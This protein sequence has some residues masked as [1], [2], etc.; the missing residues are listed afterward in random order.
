MLTHWDRGCF[1]FNSCSP[2]AGFSRNEKFPFASGS[3]RVDS[4]SASSPT[5]NLQTVTANL[6]SERTQFISDVGHRGRELVYIRVPALNEMERGTRWG[7]NEDESDD[8]YEKVILTVIWEIDGFRVV[9]IMLPRGFLNTEY[10]LIHIMDPLLA[11]VFPEGRKGH[12]RRLSV[13]LDNCRVHSSNG[14]Q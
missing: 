5:W 11:K 14:S 7:P 9:D 1:L 4:G 10:F 2:R 6:R 12:A 13:H 3:T 8:R